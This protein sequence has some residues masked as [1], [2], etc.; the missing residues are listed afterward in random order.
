M[1]RAV[2]GWQ[3]IA[4][5]LGGRRAV[6]IRVGRERSVPFDYKPVLKGKLV[7]LRPLRSADY[8][9]LYAIAGSSRF[10]GYSEERSE[11]EIGW[12]FLARAHW[13]GRCVYQIAAS[14]F[15]RP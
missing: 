7:E 8:G 4:D 9:D 13:G 5:L 2:S 6:T 14:T 3:L 11:V 12:T 1:S 15:A 10:H